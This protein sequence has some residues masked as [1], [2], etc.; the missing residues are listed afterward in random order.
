MIIDCPSGC[1]GTGTHQQS[2]EE[3]TL[4]KGWGRLKV[5]VHGPVDR[6]GEVQS[7]AVSEVEATLPRFH[8][9]AARERQRRKRLQGTAAEDFG[10]Q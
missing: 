6:T 7:H 5:Q 9:S 10:P 1:R 3:C 2:G 4:C 8:Y